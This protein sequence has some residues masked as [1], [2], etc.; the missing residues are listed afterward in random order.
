MMLGYYNN[1]GATY[2]AYD[3]EGFFLTGDQG[4]YD[5]QGF[6]HITGR[7]KDLIKWMAYQVRK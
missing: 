4:Y 2:E 6:V 1:I 3:N 7:I 5:E